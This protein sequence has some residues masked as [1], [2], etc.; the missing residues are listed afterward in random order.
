MTRIDFYVLPD[1]AAI[2]RMHYACRL[3][4]K[5]VHHGHHIVIA[6]DDEAQAHNLSDYLW[7]FKPES[8][9]PHQIQDSADSEISPIMVV[10]DKDYDEH[11]DILINL[12]QALHE[13]FSRFQRVMEIVVQ[14]E[15]CLASTRAHFQFYRERGYPLKSHTIE[16]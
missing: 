13:G 11:H 12:S 6:V 4:E 15:A 8:F 9:L 2:V 1:E 5:A 7:S 3:A 16:S 10:W 14:E